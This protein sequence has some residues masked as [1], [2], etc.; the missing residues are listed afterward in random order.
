[1]KFTRTG[2]NG[3]NFYFE[4]GRKVVVSSM[5]PPALQISSA[6][7]ELGHFIDFQKNSDAHFH[8][9]YAKQANRKLLTGAP[10]TRRQKDAIWEYEVCAWAEARGLAKQLQIR[11]GKWFE[12]DRIESLNTYRSHPIVCPVR[13]AV[14]LA[15][16]ASSRL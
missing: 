4:F 7:H 5:L 9:V 13:G 16:R 1:M 14:E 15:P 11:I 6:L 10:M 12:Q 8:S 2:N 3:D